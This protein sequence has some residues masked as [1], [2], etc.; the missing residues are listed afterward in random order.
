MFS[1]QSDNAVASMTP[2]RSRS[3][4]RRL[5]LLYLLA[6]IAL[7]IFGVRWKIEQNR[8]RMEHEKYK[9]L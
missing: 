3:A 7:M 8:K 5:K 1:K 2:S 9:E 6:F 4:R